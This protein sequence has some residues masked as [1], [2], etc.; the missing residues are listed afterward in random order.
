MTQISTVYELP[1]FPGY[2]NSISQLTPRTTFLDTSRLRMRMRLTDYLSGSRQNAHWKNLETWARSFGFEVMRDHAATQIGSSC[3]IVACRVATWLKR[4]KSGTGS[5]PDFM[6]LETTEAVSPDFI[7]DSNCI[8]FK[9]AESLGVR[10][11]VPASWCSPFALR[12]A[13]ETKFLTDDELEPVSRW[14]NGGIPANAIAATLDGYIKWLPFDMFLRHLAKKVWQAKRGKFAG[15]IFYIVNTCNAYDRGYHWVTIVVE[16]EPLPAANAISSVSVGRTHV[17]AVAVAIWYT[18]FV[19]NF[20]A[21]VHAAFITR[22]VDL[23]LSVLRIYD[24]W[25][26]T[27]QN[28]LLSFLTWASGGPSSSSGFSTVARL[29]PPV[30]VFD[31]GQVNGKRP[32]LSHLD[33]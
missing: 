24:L 15:K 30:A 25:L 7:Y 19:L 32:S 4:G 5:P 29:P 12:D 2:F 23:A 22:F 21:H 14:F 13:S 27:R 8:M 28:L 10:S 18:T 26:T 9:H 17:A 1:A 6:T 33:N 31:R 3:G 11:P 20:A 16:I